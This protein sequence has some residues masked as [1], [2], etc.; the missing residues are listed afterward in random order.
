MFDIITIYLL[1]GL[2]HWASHI[3]GCEN[4]RGTLSSV[5]VGLLEGAVFVFGWPFTLIQYLLSRPKPQE[6]KKV[7]LAAFSSK[8]GVPET[9]FEVEQKPGE[10]EE[11]FKKRLDALIDEHVADVRKKYRE[12]RHEI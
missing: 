4:C 5:I 1:I 12:E 11:T 3:L 10:D 9:L 7:S 6:L 2:A 8:P